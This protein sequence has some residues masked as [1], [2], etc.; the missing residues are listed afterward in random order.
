MEV[1]SG[2]HQSVRGAEEEGK[3]RAECVI[4]S[5]WCRC[6]QHQLCFDMPTLFPDATCD[7]TEDVNYSGCFSG[8]LPTVHPSVPYYHTNRGQWGLCLSTGPQILHPAIDEEL[9]LP[10]IVSRV[11]ASQPLHIKGFKAFPSLQRFLFLLL[12]SPLCVLRLFAQTF[13][14]LC[15][16]DNRHILLLKV[17]LPLQQT[18]P[19]TCTSE[20]N[21]K[22]HSG[23]CP[24]SLWGSQVSSVIIQLEIPAPVRTLSVALLLQCQTVLSKTG[25]HFIRFSVISLSAFHSFFFFNSCFCVS[26][27]SHR[28]SWSWQ[29]Q[30]VWTWAYSAALAW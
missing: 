20:F 5:P 1:G 30:A 4:T 26:F 22:S 8:L 9:N 14:H 17:F 19:N 7:V 29:R 10:C 24:S 23:L 28:R 16:L 12:L 13:I 6:W 15:R 27:P 3:S 21:C 11:Q 25:F 2:D 18:K